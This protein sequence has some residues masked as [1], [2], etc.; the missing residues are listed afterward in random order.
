MASP[1]DALNTRIVALVHDL[2]RLDPGPLASLRRTSPGEGCAAF[3]RVYHR[4]GLA[5]QPFPAAEAWEHAL[6]AIALLVP[7]GR[8]GERRSPHDASRPLG[9]ALFEADVSHARIARLLATPFSSRREP[10]A[11]LAR[12]LAHDGRPFDVRHLARLMLRESRGDLRL[13][14]SAYY[15][16]EAASEVHE[17][18]RTHA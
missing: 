12:R 18:E 9:R 4:A 10:L 7:T 6:H 14:A 2:L 15:G 3:W 5:D 17:K 13:L 8:E 16:A 11:R 1:D